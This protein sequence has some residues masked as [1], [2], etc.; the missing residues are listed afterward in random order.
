MMPNSYMATLHH[1]IAYRLQDYALDLSIPCHTEDTLFIKAEREDEVPTIIQIPKQLPRDKLTEIIPLKWITNYEM[2]FQNTTHVIASNTKFTKLSD[3]SIQ[4]TYEPISTSASDAS[5]SAPPIFQVLMIRHVTS[6]EEISIHSFE[7]DGSPIYTDKINNHFIWDVD[8]EMCDADC[9]CKAC[10][11][12][13]RSSCKPGHPH[14]KSD[15]PN[16]PKIGLRPVKNKS[17]HIYDRALQILRSEGLLP[18]EPE[19]PDKLLPPLQPTIPCFM[20]SSYDKDFPHLEQS[21]NSERNM[22]SRPF[23]QTTEILLD[24][25]LKQ[26][27]QAEQVLNWHSRNARVQNR[28]LHSIDQK[29]DQSTSFSEET[30][31]ETSTT[32]LEPSYESY[33]SWETYSPT[34]SEQS[35]HNANLSDSDALLNLSQIFM[36]SMTDPQPSTQTVETTS[37]EISDEPTPIV[38]EPL[39]H[40]PQAP[41]PVHRPTNVPW[42]NL[43]DSAP[44]Q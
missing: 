5:T 23:V 41:A 20:A 26:P 31:T 36:A 21:S 9:E 22:F 6:K 40:R 30:S 35:Y 17:L 8:L 12:V 33:S 32:P 15:D 28:V 3:G 44:R 11:K 7:V 14:R 29:I 38:D 25:S 16:S 19:E 4:T 18:E 39:E 42:F 43:E 24:R 27:S 37:D 13:M 10:S 2:A 1:Q 34:S